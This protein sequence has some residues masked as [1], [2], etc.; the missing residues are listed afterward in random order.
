MSLFDRIF[1]KPFKNLTTGWIADPSVPLRVDLELGR[2]CGIS[3]GDPIA[4]GVGWL[5]QPKPIA[6]GGGNPSRVPDTIESLRHLGPSS[7]PPVAAK[8]DVLYYP[9]HGFQLFLEQGRLDAA[10]INLTAEADMTAFTGLWQYRGKDVAIDTSSTRG[11]IQEILGVPKTVED[12]TIVY[13]RPG[14]QISFEWGDS[15]SLD[16]VMLGSY[17]A[18]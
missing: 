3:P 11:H 17:G 6:G 18:C 9:K 12:R 14:C 13:E 1:R 10:D 5:C 15:G 16:N 7:K 2:F 4:S 8:C